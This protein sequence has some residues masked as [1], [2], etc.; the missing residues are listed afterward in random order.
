MVPSLS[1][2]QLQVRRDLINCASQADQQ[3]QQGEH[4]ARVALGPVHAEE[5]EEADHRGPQISAR[6]ADR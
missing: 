4:Y 2:S 3:G 5:E 6:R 1:G